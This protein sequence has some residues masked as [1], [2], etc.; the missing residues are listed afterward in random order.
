[1]RIKLLLLAV[2][3]FGGGIGVTL[4]YQDVWAGKMV[5]PGGSSGDA[6]AEATKAGNKLLK[7]INV[8]AGIIASVMTLMVAIFFMTN[9]KKGAMWMGGSLATGILLYTLSYIWFSIFT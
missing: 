4:P 3:V 7:F 9:N 1:M 5:I 2:L 6:A 8:V